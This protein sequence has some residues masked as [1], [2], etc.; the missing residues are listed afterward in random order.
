MS[1]AAGPGA[2]PGRAAALTPA[3]DAASHRRASDR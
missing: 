2:R 1:Q 3:S